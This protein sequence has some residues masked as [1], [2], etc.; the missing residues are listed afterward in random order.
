LILADTG[1]NS[2]YFFPPA[3]FSFIVP[4][5]GTLSNGSTITIPSSGPASP[6]PSTITIANMPGVVSRVALK[7]SK[8]THAFPHDI[9]VLLVSPSGQS[10]LA[11]AHC[12][13]AH[14]ISNV[15]LTFDDTA[16]GYLSETGQI[17]SGTFKPSAFTPAAA[18][19]G[20][21]SAPTGPTMSALNGST[22]NGTWSL[23]I[24]DDNGGDAGSIGGWSLTLTVANTVNPSAALSLSMTGSQSSVFTG[25][26]IDYV[27]TVVNAGPAAAN[28]L[29]I[30]DTL[31]PG[32]ALVSSSISSRTS[33]ISGN[34]LNL[35]VPSLASGATAAGFIRVQAVG[36]GPATNTATV[37]ADVAD[38]YP[39]DNTA[40]FVATITQAASA[41][42]AGSYVNGN[43]FNLVL[44]GQTGEPYIVQ[45]STN[46]T[47]WSSISTNTP[48]NGTF[49]ITDSAATGSKTRYYRAF[50]APH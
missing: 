39:T 4:N 7:L 30:A 38:L 50:R 1:N 27:V 46:L 21:T 49:T 19:P 33:E 16:A 23:Y 24:L 29:V 25:N 20:L 28:N 13:G 40:S 42:L 9:N 15:D 14:S 11:L 32:V 17:S 10:V 44:N 45:F 22:A 6:Y 43:G 37:S 48:V 35:R 36:A 2:A 3:I 31:P 41:Q 34:V 47:T 26:V 5:T 8:V 18:F 12:G